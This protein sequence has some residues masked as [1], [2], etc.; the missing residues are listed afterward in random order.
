[1]LNGLS[2]NGWD[3]AEHTVV[4]ALDR[5]MCE[6]WLHA[7]GLPWLAA[8]LLEEDAGAGGGIVRGGCIRASS[9][10]L[11]LLI[12]HLL[13]QPS[14]LNRILLCAVAHSIVTELHP[15]NAYV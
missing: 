3:V 13:M 2:S 5:C 6:A 8:S 11:C 15:L 14:T 1:M 12:S 4:P 9:W 10:A 7:G